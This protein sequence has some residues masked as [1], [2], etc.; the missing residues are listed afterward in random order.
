MPTRIRALRSPEVRISPFQSVMLIHLRKKPMY[1]YEM[2]RTLR[3]DFEGVWS[4]QTGTIY[5]A[6]KRL[7][8]RGLILAEK[9]DG[10]EYYSITEKGER[11]IQE[12]IMGLPADIRFVSRYFEIL[13]VA[14]KEMRGDAPASDEIPM[15]PRFATMFEIDEMT[16]E[17]KI[18]HL[19]EVRDLHLSKLAS[20]HT[21]L[22]ELEKEMKAK[23]GET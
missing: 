19:R 20:I 6:L 9:R 8:E 10:T 23:R 18:S 21:E 22:K 14:R 5:P 3:D 13:D 4:P 15:L 17:Q 16:P 12:K 11:L 2:L 1:G 7:E